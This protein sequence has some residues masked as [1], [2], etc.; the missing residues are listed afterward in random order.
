MVGVQPDLT[1]VVMENF[2]GV[3]F[4]LL[5]FVT[6]KHVVEAVGVLGVLVGFLIAEAVVFVVSTVV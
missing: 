4:H 1:V 5:L 6:M 2:A 3:H